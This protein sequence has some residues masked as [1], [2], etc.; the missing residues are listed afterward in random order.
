MSLAAI[1]LLYLQ[2]VFEGVRGTSYH[3]DIAIDDITFAPYPCQQTCKS[4]ICFIVF[5]ALL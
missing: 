2:V 5:V 3:G 1:G 4:F